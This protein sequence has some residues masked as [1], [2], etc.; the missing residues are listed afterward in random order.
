MHIR[1]I[2][3]MQKLTKQLLSSIVR[4]LD[5]KQMSASSR[6]TIKTMDLTV[7]HKRKP[8]ILPNLTLELILISK[9]VEKASSLERKAVKPL[10]RPCHQFKPGTPTTVQL[11][12]FQTT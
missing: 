2:R 6:K 4:I 9:R 12:R 7:K 8:R 10:Y 1:S 11:M 3:Q 5:G